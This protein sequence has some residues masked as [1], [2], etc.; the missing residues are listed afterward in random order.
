MEDPIITEIKEKT[1]VGM[2]I[3]TT[4]SENRTNELWQQFMSH[5]NEIRHQVG[6][7]LYS[8]QAFDPFTMMD[9]FTSETRF[10]KWAAVEVSAVEA[11]P[12]GMKVY[13]LAGGKYAVFKH[14]GLTSTFPK[15]LQHIF[16][17]WLPD[18]KYELDSR[19]HFE[20]MGEKYLGPDNPDSE[21]DIWVPIKQ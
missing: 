5:R 8:V 18:S 21:E 6:R 13:I 4:L 11:L 7:E 20:I 15:T 10:E 12:E 17:V 14:K 3:L 2:R 9:T 1:L 19:A 16:E